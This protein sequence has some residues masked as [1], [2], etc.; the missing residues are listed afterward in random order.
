MLIVAVK[1]AF[2]E[3]L[4][5]GVKI[6]TTPAEV[7]VPKTAEP[8]GPVTVKADVE[9]T[10]RGSIA[11]VKVTV[12]FL[13]IATPCSPFSGSVELT[14]NITLV[15]G[16]VSGNDSELSVLRYLAWVR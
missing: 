9:A 5:V 6:A 8:S 11:S 16:V 12:I 4:P 15:R 10:E 3:R 13:L 2:T 1:V 14:A 7:A